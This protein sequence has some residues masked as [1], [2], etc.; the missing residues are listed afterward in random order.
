MR[1]FLFPLLAATTL[2]A[3][4]LPAADLP[5]GPSTE[6]PASSQRPAVVT[7]PQSA[8]QN[9]PSEIPHSLPPGFTLSL[10]AA[11]PLVTHP[12]MGCLDD[13]GRLFIGDAVGV[14]WNKAQLEKNPP[15]RVLLLED[16]NADGSFDKSTIFADKMTFPQ[17]AC[18]LNGSL[19]V[20]SPPS[21]WKFTD[22]DGD[23]IADQREEIVTGFDYTGNAADVH[24]PKLHPNG[25]LYW[26]HGRKNHDIKQKDGTLVSKR[27]ASGIWSCHPDGTDIQWHSLGCADNPTGLAFTSSGDLIGT[28]NLYYSNPRGDTL[29]HWLYRGVY[30]RPDQ[31]KAIEGLPRTLEKMPIIH[32]F[33]HVAVSGCTFWPSYRSAN[34]SADTP[35]RP[36]QTGAAATSTANR[37]PRTENLMVTHFNTQRLVRMELTPSGSTYTTTE[38]EFLKLN[39]PDIHL[40]DV[41]TDPRDGSLL[42]LNTGGWFRIGCPSSL[43]AKPDLR[44]SIYRI[45]LAKPKPP[46]TQTTYTTLTLESAIQNLQSQDPHTRRRAMEWIN[47]T[48]PEDHP[49]DKDLTAINEALSPLLGQDLDPPTEHSLISLSQKFYTV[50]Y[51][52]VKAAQNLTT[53]RHALLCFTPD[54][55]ASANLTAGIASDHLDSLDPDLAQVALRMVIAH[56]DAD[57]WFTPKLQKWLTDEDLAPHQ[58]TALQGYCTPLLAKPN[59]QALVTALLKH[60]SEAAQNTAIEI[61]ASQ[62]GNLQNPDWLPPLENLLTSTPNPRLLDA[63]K[64]LQSPRFDT[65]LQT[66]AKDSTQ[67]LSLRLK[68]LDT[69]KKLTLTPETFSLLLE[70]LTGTQSS[71]AARIQAATMLAKAPLTP[72]QGLTLAPALA[73]VGPVELKELLALIRKKKDPSQTT[74]FATALAKNPAL[75]SQQESIYRTTFSSAPPEI[76]ETLIHPAYAKAEAATETKK[77][78]LSSLAE[79]ATTT[80]DPAKGRDLFA[81]GAG[82]CIACHKIGDLGR[83]IGP[84]LSHIG[85]IRTERDLL[86]SILLPSATLARDY[87]AHLFETRDGQSHLGVI[88]SHTAEGLLIIDVAGQEKNL[89]H[90]QI[91]ADT[92]LPTSLM[93]IGLDQT[94]PE[95]DLLHLTAYLRSLK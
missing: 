31:M 30:E 67:P 6:I 70:S 37:E 15:N 35:V 44:G 59:T 58:H 49:A 82:T 79:K 34:G 17:G 62:R 61:I 95:P 41:I 87:E 28:V 73:T 16:T 18:W 14:N 55:A 43:T 75:I 80:G 53:L 72:A 65:K 38:H 64:K 60:A 29:M 22:T 68:A 26:C 39:D 69:Q 66:L 48:I 77:R 36:Q 21:L 45:S 94:L 24:G 19:Y 10:A 50:S 71:A 23:G 93:P 7:L 46:P 84:N 85:A 86:E 91:I 54:D 8:L 89:P 81:Q 42:L 63:L 56:P 88:R 11:P 57:E 2:P 83:D 3:A 74:A 1:R 27:L 40:T 20:C 78:Q 32:N 9:P 90:T 33:G 52:D 51:Q 13:Q 92:P 76:F 5:P 47:Q 4:D 25:R 12:I